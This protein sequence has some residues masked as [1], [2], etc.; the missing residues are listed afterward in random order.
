L[1]QVVEVIE[2][3]PRLFGSA[4]RSPDCDLVAAGMNIKTKLLLYAGEIFVKLPV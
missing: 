3:A 2:R 1:Q 4:G